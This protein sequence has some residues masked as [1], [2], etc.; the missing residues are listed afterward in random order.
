M[1]LHDNITVSW[2]VLELTHTFNF[3][4]LSIIE[5]TLIIDSNNVE[6]STKEAAP[7]IFSTLSID[8]NTDNYLH[9]YRLITLWDF[10]HFKKPQALE[11]SLAVSVDIVIDHRKYAIFYSECI[12]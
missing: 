6:Q 12:N 7:W 4:L 1:V 5:L 9:N 11:K 8:N 10:T 3:S 2:E